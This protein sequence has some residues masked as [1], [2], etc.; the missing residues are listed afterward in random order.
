MRCVRR[1]WR[2]VA[3]TIGFLIHGMA[4]RTEVLIC[5]LTSCV[6]TLRRGPHDDRGLR[7][8]GGDEG[9]QAASSP[10]D[11]DR[12]DPLWIETRRTFGSVRCWVPRAVAACRYGG[13]FGRV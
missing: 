9:R 3:G 11:G 1:R 13:L 2:L 4:V 8:A 5:R 12:V 10:G 6:G 7:P